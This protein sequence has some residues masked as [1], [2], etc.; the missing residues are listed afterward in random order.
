[1]R[2]AA[3]LELMRRLNSI[4]LITMKNENRTIWPSRIAHEDVACSD[5]GQCINGKFPS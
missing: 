2:N 1:M 3:D 5:P 4:T